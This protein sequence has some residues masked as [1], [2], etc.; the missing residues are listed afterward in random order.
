M[1]KKVTGK[2]RLPK[3]LTA[4]EELTI[5]LSENTQRQITDLHRAT[6]EM[7]KELK[8]F[9]EKSIEIHSEVLTVVTETKRIDN[10]MQSQG[11]RQIQY[12]QKNNENIEAITKQILEIEKVLTPIAEAK[13]F[14]KKV[15]AGVITIVLGAASM[16]YFV[17]KQ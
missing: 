13:A 3:D 7:S 14:V 10:A 1:S 9:A 8:N 12:E 15:I 11:Q 2:E 17:G 5:Q 16:A 6:R 4:F